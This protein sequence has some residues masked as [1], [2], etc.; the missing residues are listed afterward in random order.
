MKPPPIVQCTRAGTEGCGDPHCEHVVPH[1]RV[2]W[3]NETCGM[4]STCWT[5]DAIPV[6]CVRVKEGE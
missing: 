2:E 3:A 5:L 4:W 1:E 6:R